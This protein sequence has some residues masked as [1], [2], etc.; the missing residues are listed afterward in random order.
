MDF[1]RYRFVAA[2]F[3][4]TLLHT[5]FVDAQDKK[6][7]GT[8]A[9]FDLGSSITDKPTPDDPLFGSV[10]GESLRSLTLRL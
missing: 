8:I 10:G 7:P 1:S 3:A 5:S 2:L 4:L 6:N 9:V